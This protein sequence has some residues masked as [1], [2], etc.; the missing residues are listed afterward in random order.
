MV[1]RSRLDP[2]LLPDARAGAVEDVAGVEGLLSDGDAHSVCGIVHEDKPA[3][4]QHQA[5]QEDNRLDT[6]RS[7]EPPK[8]T[9]SVTSTVKRLY[10]PI[11]VVFSSPLTKIVAS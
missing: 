5:H 2:D 8:V 9:S 6:H 3:N 1:G 4:S 7:L 10:P 11:C